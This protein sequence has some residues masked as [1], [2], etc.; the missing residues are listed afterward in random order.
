[1]K[2]FLWVFFIGFLHH[3]NAQDSLSVKEQKKQFHLFYKTPDH[4]LREMHLDRPDITETPFT[5]DAGRFQFE[6]DAFNIYRQPLSSNRKRTDLLFLNGIA[7]AGITDFMDLEVLFSVHQWQIPDFVED[8]D[9]RVRRGFGDV[10]IR[11]KIN[12][13]GNS[14]E[15]WGI[16]LMP[17]ILLPSPERVSDGLYIPGL[18][19]IW[20]KSLPNG[21]DIGGQFEY[22]SLLNRELRFQ[23][24]EYWATLVLGKDFAKK[25]S[26]FVEYLAIIPTQSPF[27]NTFN[28]GLIYKLNPNLY[29][30]IGFNLALNANSH[31]SLFTGFSFRI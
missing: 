7:K 18:T 1:M 19:L 15:N 9:N 23:E 22:F 4:L 8:K 26:A 25:W 10:G 14:H 16:A 6:F 17:S 31:S 20:E 11:A 30:D 13:V 2:W 3:L 28:G 21:F 29:F 12:L 5:V 27:E 24:S